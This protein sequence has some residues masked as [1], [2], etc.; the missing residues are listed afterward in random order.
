MA[1]LQQRKCSR[2][3]YCQVEPL[4]FCT[5]HV[6]DSLAGI[7]SFTILDDKKVQGSDLGA[8]FFLVSDSLGKSRAEEEVIYLRELNDS[9]KGKAVQ[10][11]SLEMVCR[12]YLLMLF[13]D[14]QDVPTFLSHEPSLLPAYSLVISVNASTKD[15]LALA[16][17][18]WSSG[19]PLITVRSSGFIS[20]L[21]TQ[22]GEV[23]F[24]ETHPDSL[25]DLRLDKPFPALLDYAKSL[26]VD[27]MDSAEHGHLPA[28][29]IILRALEQYKAS[30]DGALPKITK[31]RNALK[32]L[33]TQSKRSA[34][35]ENFDEAL[36]LVIKLAR[37]SIV[38]DSITKLFS[39]PQ[40]TNLAPSSPPFWL[41]LRAVKE[42]VA[43]ENLLPLTGSLPDMKATSK[44]YLALQSL[45]RTKAKED[46][47]AVTH[48]LHK[49]LVSLGLP[50]TVIPDEEIATFV[51]HAAYLE[52]MRGTNLAEEFEKGPAS[53]PS[54]QIMSK[55]E[56]DEES[57]VQW[58][59]A[60]RVAEEFERKNGKF[61]EKEEDESEMFFLAKKLLER[62]GVKDL[63]ELPD[64]LT[65]AIQEM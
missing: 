28:V 65:Q 45:Y 63:G 25:V 39:D 9:V 30:S 60:L 55:L 42:F 41:L 50:T 35:E 26:D 57:C 18:C 64:S 15:T 3:L 54:D 53:L 16:S 59:V 31:E 62:Y 43:T 38:P 29:V 46:L 5:T 17:A 49:L 58:F 34:D 32:A 14:R 4:E 47:I 7:G 20:S 40:C 6:I 48:H 44:G 2:I 52:V 11:V 36:A 10:E 51:K 33:I 24:V 19:V 37:P 8:N 21:R 23:A 56:N 27:A 61:P 13:L 22:V 12:V 1:R